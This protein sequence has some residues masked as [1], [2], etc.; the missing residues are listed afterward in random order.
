MFEIVLY[1]CIIHLFILYKLYRIDFTR[2]KIFFVHYIKIVTRS[3][4]LLKSIHIRGRIGWKLELLSNIKLHLIYR[5]M[6]LFDYLHDQLKALIFGFW[7]VR[8]LGACS[9]NSKN[10]YIF[11]WDSELS[12]FTT[13]LNC[14]LW[15]AREIFCCLWGF[16]F[17]RDF[18]RVNIFKCFYF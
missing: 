5:I 16:N 17:H 8:K 1:W 11:I 12:E 13:T 2:P 9:E 14:K 18:N 7:R 10:L 3:D 4:N 6:T 15:D